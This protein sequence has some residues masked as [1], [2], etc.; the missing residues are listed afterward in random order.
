MGMITYTIDNRLYINVTNKCTNSCIFCIRNT[1][2]GLGEG[3][4]LWLEKDPTAE[5]I[6]LEIKDPQKYDEIVFCGYGEPLIRLDVV[7]EVAKK[8]KEITSVPLRV[9]TNGHASYIHKKNVPQLLSGIIDRISISLNAP[10]KERYNEICK[11]FSEDIY[12]HV[13][14]FIKESKKYIKEVWVSCV[15]IISQEEIEE[16]RKIAQKLG[17]NFRLRAYEE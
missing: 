11:P 6:L 3:Y 5:E 10:N 9:N 4:D 7:I 12:D 14:E 1:E 17:V 2:R 16:C 8:L 13:I 15:D